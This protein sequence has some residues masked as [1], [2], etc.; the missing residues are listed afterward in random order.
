M[1]IV[2]ATQKNLVTG[3]GVLQEKHLHVKLEELGR[4]RILLGAICRKHSSELFSGKY[5]VERNGPRIEH[6]NSFNDWLAN[7]KDS[8]CR[9]QPQIVHP[10]DCTCRKLDIIVIAM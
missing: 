10:L 6:V 1:F 8:S 5:D 2:E 7:E 4:L 9:F 3:G